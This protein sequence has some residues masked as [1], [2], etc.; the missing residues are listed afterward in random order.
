M[1]KVHGT[2]VMNRYNNILT[3][4]KG[5]EVQGRTGNE[6]DTF[7]RQKNMLRRLNPLEIKMYDKSLALMMNKK[8]G[9]LVIDD[10]MIGS[11]AKDVENKSL[12]ERKKAKEGIKTDALNCSQVGVLFGM[13]IQ[14]SG[15]TQLHKVQ[16]LLRTVPA[17]THVDHRPAIKFDRGYGKES[18]VADPLLQPF[19]SLTVC[20]SQGSRCCFIFQSEADELEKRWKGKK[21]FWKEV[22]DEETGERRTVFDD[23]KLHLCKE[24]YKGW[25]FESSELLGAEVRVASKDVQMDGGKILTIN[26]MC[27]RDVFDR[28]V[29]EKDLRFLGSG[30]IDLEKALTWVAIEKDGYSISNHLFSP[31]SRS[32]SKARIDIENVLSQNCKAM[33]LGQRTADWFTLKL[34][35]SGTMAG[36]VYSKASQLA[37]DEDIEHG[38]LEELLDECLVS[39]FGRHSGGTSAMAEGTANEE[40]TAQKFSS[41]SFVKAFYD[42][43]LLQW[44]KA[45]YLGVSPDGVAIV[46]VPGEEYKELEEK[47]CCVEI[48]TRVKPDPIAAAEN[49]RQQHGYIVTCSYDDD[50]FKGCVPS[51]NRKQVVH[52][53][54]VSDLDWGAFVTAKVEEGE[55]SIVQIVFVGM[56]KMTRTNT[57]KHCY[58]SKTFERIHEG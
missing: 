39:W 6:E 56:A 36:K 11:R 27:M 51:Q 54:L 1:G 3:C 49:A 20:A 47:R 18:F 52:Q 41:M 12:S 29:A 58:V 50:V 15:E 37:D 31:R 19:K 35:L 33:T 25:V 9:S 14:C 16:E 30:P 24:V 26:A 38:L 45:D 4:L 48:K 34:L 2:S 44:N 13:R 23:A 42:V 17:M 28:K 8:S 53:A 40:P 7:M 32:T 55:G 10:E 5:Y 21:E 46:K 43:G 57:Q 22:E